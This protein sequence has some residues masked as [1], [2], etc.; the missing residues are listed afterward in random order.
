MYGE[1]NGFFFFFFAAHHSLWDLTSQPGVEPGP[2]AEVAQILPLG[3][4]RIQ[5]LNL[6]LEL[7]FLFPTPRGF[8]NISLTVLPAYSLS[9]YMPCAACTLSPKKEE[10]LSTQH[11]LDNPLGRGSAPSPPSSTRGDDGAAFGARTHAGVC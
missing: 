8:L 3:I 1:F 9:V 4:P 2:L 11:G 6:F 10:D 5:F 7:A